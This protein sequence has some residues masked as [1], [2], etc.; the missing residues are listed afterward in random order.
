LFIISIQIGVDV[1][2]KPRSNQRGSLKHS[3]SFTPELGARH[4]IIP[5][6]ELD[7]FYNSL[8]GVLQETL[9]PHGYLDE[10]GRTKYRRQF[11]TFDDPERAH[12][13]VLE[14]RL[15]SSHARKHRIKWTQQD[16][17]RIRGQIQDQVGQYDLGREAAVDASFTEVIR[18]G[19]A[20]TALRGGRVL[21]LALNQESHVAQFIADE[22]EITVNGIAT[23][24]DRF[25]YPYSSFLPHF[26]VARVMRDS[27]PDNIVD[28]V[29]GIKELLPLD[30]Q[31]EPISFTSRQ[32]VN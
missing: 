21:S 29:V 27:S 19:D 20:D 9:P 30:V 24:L 25:R 26:S 2:K 7:S 23:S 31:L 17:G 4:R 18:L 5:T 3:R 22:H 1:S 10:R 28:A 11:T 6:P 12:V 14:R 13:R 8:I 32:D 16:V 15:S